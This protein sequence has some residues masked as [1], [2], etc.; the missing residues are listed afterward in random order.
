MESSN[1]K[2]VRMDSLRI[3]EE[4]LNI[5]IQF[6]AQLRSENI[7]TVYEQNAFCVKVNIFRELSIASF[8][9]TLAPYEEFILN[10]NLE[11]IPKMQG[12]TINFF[13]QLQLKYKNL[14]P[15]N[16]EIVMEYIFILYSLS[17][18]YI[19]ERK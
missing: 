4:F 9:S 10:K 15:L 8:Y 17:K 3:K 14:L 2:Q 13:Q 5:L 1:D 16:Q 11:I 7:I 6:A 12:I 19:N 18:Q